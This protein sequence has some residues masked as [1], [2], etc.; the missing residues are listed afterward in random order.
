MSWKP[1]DIALLLFD[2]K[3]WLVLTGAGISTESGIPDFRTPQTGL[4]EHYDPIEVLSVEALFERPQVFFGVGFR[5]LMRFKNARPNRAHEI[6]AEW[7]KLGLVEAIVTQ[8]IDGLHTEAGSRRVLEIHGHLRSGHCIL[9]HASFPM[10]TLEEKVAQGEIPPRCLCGGMIRPDVVLFGDMLPPCFEEATELAHRLPLL[11][12][13]SSLQVSPANFLPSYAP[14]LGIIN[15]TPTP[16]D[17]KARFV[18]HER[19]SLA[20]EAIHRELLA[21]L[22]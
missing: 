5:V 14:L 12:I 10:D 15:L 6:L 9:C 21:K 1:E 13:G 4:W 8:N 18:I 20:L 3:P 22:S 19:A 17:W 11:V 16:F 7:E 2:H